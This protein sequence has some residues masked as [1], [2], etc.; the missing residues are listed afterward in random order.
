MVYVWH[1]SATRVWFSSLPTMHW[2]IVDLFPKI[3]L[4]YCQ[5]IGLIYCQKSGWFIEIAKNRVFIELIYWVDL[6]QKN[7]VELLQKKMVDLLQKKPGL[8][9][10]WFPIS[11]FDKKSTRFFQC[12]TLLSVSDFETNGPPYR[13]SFKCGW[14][15]QDVILYSV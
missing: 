10:T 14:L 8:I 6:L 4:I 11:I 9:L 1:F 15:T 3:G 2:L 13:G 7:W 12:V 5:K